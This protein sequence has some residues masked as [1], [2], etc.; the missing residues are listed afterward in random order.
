MANPFANRQTPL[1][2]VPI[3]AATLAEVQAQIVPALSSGADVIEWRVDGLRLGT[4]ELAAAQ[5]LAARIQANGQQLLVTL[6]TQQQGGLATA[7]QYGQQVQTWCAR[8]RPDMVDVEFGPVAAAV[9]ATLP[10]LPVVL[11]WHDF[12]GTPADAVLQQRLCDMAALK[13]ALLKLALM[14]QTA[15]DVLRILQLSAWAHQHLD[16]PVALMGMGNLG[17]I[18]RVAG[19]LFGTALTFASAGVSSAPGQMPVAEVQRLLQDF[20]K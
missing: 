19:R 11:S 15:G 12:A 7:Q 4:T 17:R 3:M 13:P 2:A 6:R 16:V 14:P 10:P 5:Q 18:T 8:L 9:M 20:G 1:V